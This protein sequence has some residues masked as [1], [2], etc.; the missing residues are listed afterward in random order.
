MKAQLEKQ[1]MSKILDSISANLSIA[2]MEREFIARAVA[3]GISQE[4]AEI[5]LMGGDI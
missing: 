1:K 5:F 3:V 2:E 4:S